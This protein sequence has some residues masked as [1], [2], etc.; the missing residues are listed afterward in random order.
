VKPIYLDVEGVAQAVSLSEMSIRRLIHAGT[1]PKARAI[2]G[3][4]VAWLVSEVEAWAESR[5]VSD[6]FPP[7]RG[8][9]HTE[10]TFIASTT[11][12]GEAA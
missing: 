11:A 6:L 2:S 5:P 1:F 3:R 7:P 12:K 4:R 9:N 8:P 10:S